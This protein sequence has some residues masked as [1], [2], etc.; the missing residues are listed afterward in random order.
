MQGAGDDMIEAKYCSAT[1]LNQ[2][3]QGCDDQIVEIKNVMGQ[4]YIANASKGKRIR[5]YGT[6]GN[7]LGSFL[8][9]SVVEVFGNAQDSCAN[10]MNDG[11]IIIHGMCGDALGY[12]MR[13]GKVFVEKDCGSRCGV[14]MKATKEKQPLIIIGGVVQDFFGEYL[15]GGTLIVLNLNNE[16]RCCGRYCGSG[17]HGGSIYLRLSEQSQ[18]IYLKDRIQKVSNEKKQLID[19]ALIEYANDLQITL[20]ETMEFYEVILN[21]KNPYE[22]LYVDN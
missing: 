19:D 17:A 15:S 3:I 4:R 20:P 9:G 22:G 12:G 16:L 8:D 21:D 7:N 6:C 10:T 18:A 2:L 11:K 14:H 5:I 1:E 13:G